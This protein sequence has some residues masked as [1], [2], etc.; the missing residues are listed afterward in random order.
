MTESWK[1]S[2]SAAMM[3]KSAALKLRIAS[4]LGSAVVGVV[5]ACGAKPDQPRQA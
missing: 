5:E 3:Q 4:E 2:L 1:E